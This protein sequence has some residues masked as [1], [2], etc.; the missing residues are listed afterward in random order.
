MC[1]K[2]GNYQEAKAKADNQDFQYV[3]TLQMQSYVSSVAETKIVFS[4]RGVHV[5]TH[6][7]SGGWFLTYLEVKLIF[8]LGYNVTFL[9]FFSPCSYRCVLNSRI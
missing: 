7:V 6:I 1:Y 4:T 9:S 8:Q 3:F 2:F 5:E